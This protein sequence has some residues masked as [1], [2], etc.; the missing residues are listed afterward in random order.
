VIAGHDPEI[1]PPRWVS[2]GPALRVQMMFDQGWQGQ[3]MI[4]TARSV[5][6]H[7]RDGAP[8]SIRYF[9]KTICAG[10]RTAIEA[11]AVACGDKRSTTFGG[12]P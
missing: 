10:A 8:L 1:L 7:K 3:M 11:D 12:D 4:D 5:M 9:E 2:D 6:Q